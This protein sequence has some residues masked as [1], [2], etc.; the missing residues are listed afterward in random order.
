MLNYQRVP[1][2]VPFFGDSIWRSYKINMEYPL[3]ICHGS[4]LNITTSNNGK[5]TI[6]GPC[7][8]VFVCLPGRVCS[9]QK[10][11]WGSMEVF[12]C[13]GHATGLPQHW[14]SCTM[15]RYIMITPSLF[16]VVTICV[17]V[18]AAFFE[19]VFVRFVYWQ[20]I[21]HSQAILMFSRLL[22]AVHSCSPNV[23]RSLDDIAAAIESYCQAVRM[24][25]SLHVCF[26]NLATLYMYLEDFHKAEAG[27]DFGGFWTMDGRSLGKNLQESGVFCS[28]LLVIGF[29]YRISVKPMPF[30][31]WGTLG[32]GALRLDRSDH[33]WMGHLDSSKFAVFPPGWFNHPK[34]N[35][36]I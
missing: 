14:V 4:L 15:L 13:H 21:I 11:R 32:Y 34:K 20:D 23:P 1:G 7:S 5:S 10:S 29:S 19:Y 12:L 3:V 25:P 35:S 16:I 9:L 18:I 36:V 30:E 17:I 28:K 33:R 31:R 2:F 8:I 6:T 22:S 24:D 27:G 26:A